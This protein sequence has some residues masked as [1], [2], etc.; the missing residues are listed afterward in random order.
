VAYHFALFESTLAKGDLQAAAHMFREHPGFVYVLQWTCGWGVGSVGRGVCWPNEYENL[1]DFKE[2]N[3]FQGYMA[4]HLAAASGHVRVVETLLAHVPEL[5]HAVDFRLDTALCLTVGLR[6]AG[7]DHLRVVELLLLAQNNPIITLDVTN[8]QRSPVFRKAAQGGNERIMELLLAKH[9]NSNNNRGKNFEVGNSQ[10]SM[11]DTALHTALSHGHE[12]IAM[13]LLAHEP[14]LLT[15][16][17]EWG[18]NMLSIAAKQGHERFFEMVLRQPNPVVESSALGLAFHEAVQSGMPKIVEMLLVHSPRLADEISWFN[19]EHAATPTACEAIAHL[20]L[21]HKP[22]LI[23]KVDDRGTAL[24]LAALIGLEDFAQT[25]LARKPE[26]V[27]EVN[28]HH[29]TA[30][31]MAVSQG[32]IKIVEMLL[33]FRPGLIDAVDLQGDSVLHTAINYRNF[34]TADLLL[35]RKPGLVYAL[36]TRGSTPLHKLYEWKW[37]DWSASAVVGVEERLWVLNLE[38]VFTG[39]RDSARPYED[40]PTSSRT[41]LIKVIEQFVDIPLLALLGTRDLANIVRDYYVC[42][43]TRD[44][45]CSARQLKEATGGSWS[46]CLR[47]TTTAT[48]TEGK[49]SRRWGIR[50]LAM[51]PPRWSTPFTP[52]SAMAMKPLR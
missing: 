44:P 43:T 3:S 41:R 8:N 48:T 16:K 5:V 32:R 10:L 52:H 2:S 15:V 34:A 1:D 50:E 47:N 14:R 24:H 26:L 51:T 33:D 35:T 20:L 28:K 45:L 17:R 37:H 19:V 11:V 40:M 29:H 23:D 46:C 27:G 4:L 25:L 22:D 38:A 49:I 21:A 12:A 42:V 36:N 39:N 9:N 30:L 7:P 31:W 13:L 18:D 6:D